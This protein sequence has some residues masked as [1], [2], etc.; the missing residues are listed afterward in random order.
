MERVDFM[1][2]RLTEGR[3]ATAS[4]PRLA[5]DRVQTP[6]PGPFNSSVLKWFS[7]EAYIPIT[8]VKDFIEG[9]EHREGFECKFTIRKTEDRLES[10]GK[11]LIRYWCSYGPTDLRKD[12]A[13]ALSGGN[14]P[15]VGEGSRPSSQRKKLG[16]S[17]ARGCRCHFAVIYLKDRPEACLIRWLSREHRDKDGGF[18]HGRMENTAPRVDDR[19]FCFTHYDGV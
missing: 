8:R 3:V 14:V 2:E 1:I 10:N 12:V 6:A 9:E 17:S 18:C 16:F 7:E 19:S 11:K 13:L 5:C 15:E 4:V